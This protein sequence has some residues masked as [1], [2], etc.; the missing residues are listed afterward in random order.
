MKLSS[1][2]VPN[3]V[4]K[5]GKKEEREGGGEEANSNI[6]VSMKRNDYIQIKKNWL[7]HKLCIKISTIYQNHKFLRTPEYITSL[8]IK[9]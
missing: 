2:N 7:F 1:P 9:L 8:R 4:T 3:T 6:P 5:K